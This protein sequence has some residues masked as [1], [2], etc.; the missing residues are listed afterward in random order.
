MVGTSVINY[1]YICH[2][3][4]D[5]LGIEVAALRWRYWSS[6]RSVEVYL[7]KVSSQSKCREREIYVVS[8][9]DYKYRER[10]NMCVWCAEGTVWAV[11][12]FNAYPFYYSPVPA[13]A[14]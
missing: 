2:V 13:V 4:Y 12:L 8:S 14:S 10:C 5:S 11:T 3:H 6:R 7:R 1:C 9:S